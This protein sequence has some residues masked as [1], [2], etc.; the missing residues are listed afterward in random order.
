MRQKLPIDFSGFKPVGLW[1]R[2]STNG[3][4]KG[5]SPV[6]Q[7]HQARLYADIK[8]W[9]VK[10]VYRLDAVSGKSILQHPET[11]RML[12]D[13]KRGH[14]TGLICSKLARLAR[15]TRELLACSEIF[16][17]C[18]ADLVCLHESID[19]TIPAGRLMYTLIAALAEWEREEIAQRVAVSI[20]MRAKL[21]KSL[22]GVAPFG[23]QWKG[24]RLVP[25][26]DEAP[27]L[28]RVFELFAEH[29]RKTAV[30]RRLNDAGHRTRKG[31]RFT[32][33]TIGQLLQNP[34]A[35][36]LHRSNYTMRVG[37]KKSWVLKPQEQWVYT[38]VEPIISEEL[39]DRCQMIL[40]EQKR[41][42]PRSKSE[43]KDLRKD[44]P[45]QGEASTLNGSEVK[46]TTDRRH[47]RDAVGFGKSVC[48]Y[49]LSLPR[50]I[51]PPKGYPVSP[52]TI[53]E[54]LR[55]KRLDIGLTQDAAGKLLGV[56][57]STVWNWEH[58][59]NPESKHY[60]KITQFLGYTPFKEK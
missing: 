39:W 4:A 28:R 22:G 13:I 46:Q 18:E 47:F 60:S 43:E 50:P 26:P 30:A 49:T 15:N 36:G 55:K 57:G 24:R 41:I 52:V 9:E 17:Q 29:R 23:Y 8:D 48:Y 25:Q 19:T 14:I 44:V 51:L 20:P 45:L 33:M 5:D 1:I 10:E 16:Q 42:P 59:Q 58:G 2:V 37:N 21:G 12:Q 32:D 35:K 40:Q 31:A 53:G 11:Q 3:Q 6:H 7:E 38:H 54:H 34:T 56:T 27:I